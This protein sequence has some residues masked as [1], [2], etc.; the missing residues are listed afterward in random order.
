VCTLDRFIGRSFVRLSFSL[1]FHLPQQ[2]DLG[3]GGV[4]DAAWFGHTT[5]VTSQF[6]LAIDPC[7]QRPLVSSDFISIE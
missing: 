3:Y 7:C 5:G 1:S 6:D 2:V 4:V